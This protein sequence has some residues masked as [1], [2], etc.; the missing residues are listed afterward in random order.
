MRIFALS[1][2]HVDYATNA[3]WVH[4]LS[5]D[6]Y[7][8]DV[9]ILAGDLTDRTHLF[10]ECLAAF[11]RR[12][13]KVLFVPGNHDLW[14]ARESPRETSLQK[15]E[16]VR[17]II[18]SSGAS[19]KPYREDGV[20]LVPLLGWYDYSFGEPGEKLKSE[21]MDFYAC[22]WPA[23]FGVREIVAH[24][25]AFNDHPPPAAGDAVITF[26]H[27]LPRID[28]MPAF[29]PAGKRILYPVLGSHDLDR[30]LRRYDPL[31]HVY[32]HSHVN[33]DVI[34]DGV[35]YVNNAYGYP[36]EARI[37]AKLLLCIHDTKAPRR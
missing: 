30:Q 29:I 21:W 17:A 15:F 1:D 6:D 3:R 7:Q 34:M 11:C 14:V 19:M 24:F 8:E 20:T 37:A 35:R 12:F 27:F 4:D 33:R 10:E 9:L 31:I 36:G 22:R 18:E 32:G 23:G 2:V 5:R 16:R 28:V 26:S 13:K 25:T